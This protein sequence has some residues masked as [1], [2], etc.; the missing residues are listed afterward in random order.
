MGQYLHRLLSLYRGHWDFSVLLIFLLIVLLLQVAVNFLG[1]GPVGV[2]QS[3]RD[4][5]QGRGPR[6]QAVAGGPVITDEAGLL[7]VGWRA[8]AVNAAV[9]VGHLLTI[10]GPRGQ[11]EQAAGGFTLG[12]LGHWWLREWLWQ[13][14]WLCGTWAGARGWPVRGDNHRLS[15]VGGGH[16][17][18]QDM[19][20]TESPIL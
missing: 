19:S 10:P 14:G 15:E 17:W 1:A 13:H 16:T 11:Q 3:N 20:L 5:G 8:D 9:P 12:K 18:R 4:T 7:T 2:S 6:A